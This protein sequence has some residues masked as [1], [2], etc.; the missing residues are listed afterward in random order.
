MIHY[1]EL[2][3]WGCPSCGY[4]SGHTPISQG[5]FAHWSCGECRKSCVLYCGDELP[6]PAE[7]NG[8]DT[9]GGA[10]IE[11]TPHPRAGTP[12]HGRPDTRPE[13]GGEFFGVRGIGMGWTPG[14]FMCGAED[15]LHHD[16]AAFVQTRE[17]GLRALA[18]FGDVETKVACA[19][20]LIA[21]IDVLVRAGLLSKE[22]GDA[23]ATVARTPGPGRPGRSLT[24]GAWLDYREH[25]PDRIQLKVGA[26]D[27]HVTH[28]RTLEVVCNGSVLTEERLAYARDPDALAKLA[29][30]YSLNYFCVLLEM[31]E[32]E[33][34]E[35]ARAR[36]RVAEAAH[37]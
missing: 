35:A 24:R 36:A 2:N 20:E 28:L 12:A 22:D 26:C 19:E 8:S 29:T 9:W 31:L 16:M 32:I 7:W 25:S 4:R 37:G 34:R 30:V 13:G 3:V 1:K 27:R 33:I 15:G 23:K 5:P 21:K 6:P 17:A 18:M 10:R 14:C 11:L